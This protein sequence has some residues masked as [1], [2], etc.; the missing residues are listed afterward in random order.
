MNIEAASDAIWAR[1]R[2]LRTRSSSACIPMRCQTALLHSDRQADHAISWSANA[3]PRLFVFLAS[4]TI[5]S[6]DRASS[7]YALIRRIEPC[8]RIER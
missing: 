7:P 1:A 4:D 8:D 2:P 5:D 6:D 3:I